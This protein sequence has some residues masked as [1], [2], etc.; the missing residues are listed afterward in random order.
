MSSRAAAEGVELGERRARDGDM[1]TSRCREMD[2]VTLELSA[3]NEQPLAAGLPI[4]PEHEVVDDELAA[5]GEEV[6]QRLPAVRPVERVV[7]GDMLP[8]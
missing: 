2:D 3:Q 5:A 1:V 8:G 4:G 6:A 7:L